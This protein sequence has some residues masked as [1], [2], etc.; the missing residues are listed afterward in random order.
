MEGK[1]LFRKY[2]TERLLGEGTFGRVYKARSL[3]T[4]ETVAIK[5]INKEQVNKLF[6]EK[7]IKR[8]ISTMSL[9]KHPNIVELKEVMASKTRIY[10]VLEHLGGGDLYTKILQQGNLSENRARKYFHQLIRAVDFCHSRGVCHR[11]LKLEN[12]LLH[13][14]EETLK[15]CD[16]GLATLP[17]QEQGKAD[18]LLYTP[19]GAFAYMA[20]EIA[21]GDKYDG[22]MADI[23]SC[24]VI[25]YTLVA[26]YPPFQDEN[27]RRMLWKIRIAEY[28]FPSWFSQEIKQLIGKILVPD[29]WE[30]ITM[31]GII[32][33]PWFR[34]Q[35]YEHDY[36]AIES[37]SSSSS[38][39]GEEGL[40]CFSPVSFNAFDFILSMASGLDLSGLF[41]AQKGKLGATFV[42][43][44]STMEVV[45]AVES[46]AERLNFVVRGGKEMKRLVLVG[47]KVGRKG[48][49]VVGV[50]VFEV[51]PEVNVV[52][53]FR[54]AGDSIEYMKLMEEEVRPAMEGV[55]WKWQGDWV[56]GRGS[57]VGSG[58][59]SRNCFCV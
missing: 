25:L 15:L 11:D 28:E 40:A 55:A 49:L 1:I 22:K 24:G 16:F 48:R 18:G 5:V 57:S 45:K 3:E 29:P 59:S 44:C 46:M 4:G 2:E 14:N 6:M 21:R 38:N 32:D 26:G 19:C 12:I 8:E 13:S 7:Q 33:S 42:S 27:R 35:E 50:S 23:W 58:T 36:N 41:G 43:K 20:P 56:Q 10:L 52:E 47:G 17:G 9:V 31:D 34:R 54:W 39:S 53:F 30:R 51:A 37:S